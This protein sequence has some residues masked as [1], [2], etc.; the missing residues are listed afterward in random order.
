MNKVDLEQ[1]NLQIQA[2]RSIIEETFVRLKEIDLHRI[3]NLESFN[4]LNS[5]IRLTNTSIVEI[6][7]YLATF[8][9]LMAYILLIEK[10]GHRSEQFRGLLQ[11]YN[12]ME[13]V[14]RDILKNRMRQVHY[15]ERSIRATSLG[16]RSWFNQRM[17]LLKIKE[18]DNLIIILINLYVRDKDAVEKISR[19]VVWE[20]RKVRVVKLAP[21]L[22]PVGTPLLIIIINLTYS[23]ANQFSQNKKL[24]KGLLQ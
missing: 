19:A 3:Q 24:L 4:N 2:L 14:I 18:E 23:W 1:G 22:S 12:I 7:K 10:E 17:L 9:K 15:A 21:F 11:R 13:M 6:R 8:E 5:F 16:F 20:R